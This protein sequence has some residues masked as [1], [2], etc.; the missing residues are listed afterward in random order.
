MGQ[1]IDPQKAEQHFRE[2]LKKFDTAMLVTHT[3]PSGP[4]HA[5]PMAVAETDA[6]GSIWFISRAD[7]PKIDEISQDRDILAVFAEPRQYL[8]VSGRAELSKDRARIK[9]VWKESFKTW[10]DKGADDPNIVL[11][12]LNPSEAEYWDN[13][14]AQGLRFALKYAKAYVTGETLK[15]PGEVEAHAKVQL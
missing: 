8:S 11:I 15:G 3:S 7:A 2:L 9:K 6:D 4:T 10:F 5:R 12:R 14:G 1:A 13:T